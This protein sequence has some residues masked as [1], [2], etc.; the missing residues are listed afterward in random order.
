MFVEYFIFTYVCIYV[1]LK[2][3]QTFFDH[4]VYAF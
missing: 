2:F 4:R 3:G 1:P